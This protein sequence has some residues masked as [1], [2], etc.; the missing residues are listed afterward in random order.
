MRMRA[1]AGGL[2]LPPRQAVEL[3]PGGYHL[4][5]MDLKKPLVV[6]ET[7]PIELSF[8][9]APAARRSRGSTCR[10]AP[11]RR[12]R[13]RRR[14]G[15]VIGASSLTPRRFAARPRSRRRRPR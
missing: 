4:M 9:D 1:V 8:V 7:V 5:L 3:K 10:C 6:G 11:P 2:D 12:G 15:G 13:G 14:R